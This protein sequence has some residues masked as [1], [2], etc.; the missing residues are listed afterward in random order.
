MATDECRLRTEEGVEAL[1]EYCAGRL[2]AADAVVLESHLAGCA[3][4]REFAAAQQTVW[5]S[6]DAWEPAIETQGFQSRLNAR[7][8]EDSTPAWKDRL[9]AWSSGISWK[10][11]IP[12]AA[13]FALWAAISA[14]PRPE[15]P[16]Q[17]EQVRPEAVERMLEDVDMLDQL[18]LNAQ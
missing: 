17:A 16:A 11:A 5:Q 3:P 13:A 15:I 12:M 8:A 7:L 14:P 6:L 9:R 18:K 1:L 4:C 10:P 2:H